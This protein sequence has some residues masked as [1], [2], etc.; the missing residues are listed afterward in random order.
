MY[1]LIRLVEDLSALDLKVFYAKIWCH[2]FSLILQFITAEVFV[3]FCF[4]YL[5]TQ[6]VREKEK[7]LFY[8]AVVAFVL[9]IISFFKITLS[10]VKRILA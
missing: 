3:W 8:Y 4:T 9:K 7:N 1:P 5:I 2:N 6:R 10:F